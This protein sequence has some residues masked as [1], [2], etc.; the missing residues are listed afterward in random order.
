[1]SEEKS[2]KLSGTQKRAK[3]VQIVD[4]YFVQPES[5]P[6]V[7]DSDRA[8][9]FRGVTLGGSR[10]GRVTAWQATHRYYGNAIQ[11]MRY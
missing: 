10:L 7:L 11:Q 9:R 5:T 4:S 6:T 3:V 8:G 2:S 1:L